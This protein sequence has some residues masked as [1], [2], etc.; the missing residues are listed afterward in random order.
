MI[1]EEV[2]N[3]YFTDISPKICFNKIGAGET[4]LFL[5]GIGGNKSNWHRQMLHL[6]NICSTISWD[7]RGYGDSEDY[8]SELTLDD[9]STDLNN[10]LK[11]CKIEKAH[12]VGLSMGARIA[13]NYY[14]N[15]ASKVLSLTLCNCFY[16][17]GK[18]MSKQK[19]DEYINLREKPLLEG[20]TFS[21]IAPGIIRSLVKT[22]C[23]QSVIDE[24]TKSISILRKNPYLKCIKTAFNFDLSENLVDFNVPTQLIFST[25]DKLTPLSIG[26][27]MHNKI[28]NS[29]L[30]II[31]NAGH[32][33]NLEQPDQFNKI[34]FEF[35][36]ANITN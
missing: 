30:S 36:K 33:S 3:K 31:Q 14:L 15:N 20:K 2:F 13:M 17:F 1:K 26:E 21:D 19:Q 35:I 10:L 32:L 11:F 27:T 28:P 34:L 18:S 23:K 16:S 29:K 8:T 4:V 25:H 6:S 24:L 22:D 5:H 12:F 7:A 9:F